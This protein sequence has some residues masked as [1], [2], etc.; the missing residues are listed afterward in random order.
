MT[1]VATP[2]STIAR[3]RSPD[4]RPAPCSRS[5]RFRC[6]S[7]SPPIPGSCCWRG[8]SPAPLERATP[9]IAPA[10]GCVVPARAWS[11]ALCLMLLPV[12]VVHARSLLERLE[13]SRIVR[14]TSQVAQL[15]MQR[16]AMAARPVL[17]ANLPP[18]H[19]AAQLDPLAVAVPLTTGSHYLL[20]GQRSR[21]D[22]GLRARARGRAEVGALSQPGARAGAGRPPRRGGGARRASGHA[23]SADR[24]RSREAGAARA[25]TARP[26]RRRPTTRRGARSTRAP[27]PASLRP[28]RLTRSAR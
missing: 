22:R 16:G 26:T 6:A 21:G 11:A 10:S 23:R 24:G 15:A 19:R 5:P 7:R 25:S 12:L 28:C 18:L 8:S 17:Q 14:T 27:S 3:W 13:A 9:S 2:P 1:S 4:A 20:L